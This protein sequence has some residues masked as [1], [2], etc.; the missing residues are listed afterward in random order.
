MGEMDMYAV[1]TENGG[2]IITSIRLMN[3]NQYQLAGDI[4][5]DINV[6]GMGD[7]KRTPQAFIPTEQVMR[8]VRN[9]LWDDVNKADSTQV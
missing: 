4:T 5:V 2:T 7:I 6:E 9:Y 3:G 1:V 8:V